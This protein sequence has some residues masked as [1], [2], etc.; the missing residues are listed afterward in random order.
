M[1]EEEEQVKGGREEKRDLLSDKEQPAPLPLQKGLSLC[2]LASSGNR[3]LRDLLCP[4]LSLV[5]FG[6]VAQDP[7]G[8]SVPTLY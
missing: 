8:S 4:C 1:E 6:W 7:A 2:E 3:L 5:T